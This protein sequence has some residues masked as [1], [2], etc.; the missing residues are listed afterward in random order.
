MDNDIII[1]NI[2]LFRSNPKHMDQLFRFDFLFKRKMEDRR[3]K[4]FN[5]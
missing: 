5:N 3:P 4:A 1:G 2:N